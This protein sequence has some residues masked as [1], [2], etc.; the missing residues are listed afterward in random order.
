MAVTAL[1]VESPGENQFEALP[2]IELI[3]ALGGD[4]AGRDGLADQRLGVDAA[5]VVDDLDQYLLPACRADTSSAR[6]GLPAERRA[7]SFSIP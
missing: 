1:A 2:R 7:A 3:G 4:D 5:S 6:A